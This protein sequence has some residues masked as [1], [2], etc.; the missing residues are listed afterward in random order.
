[1]IIRWLQNIENGA[2]MRNKFEEYLTKFEEVG[3][4]R[5]NYVATVMIEGLPGAVLDEQLEFEGGAIGRVVGMK[6]DRLKVMLLNGKPISPSEKVAR[7]GSKVKIKVSDKLLGKTTDALANPIDGADLAENEFEEREIDSKP[8]GIFGRKRINRRFSTGVMMVD[9]LVPLGKGQRELVIGDRKTGKS[10]LLLQATL[11][12]AREGSVCIYSAVAKK[13]SEIIDIQR[14]M[15]GQG[16]LNQVIIVATS[17][18]DTAGE[19]YIGPY[20]AMTMAEYFRDKGRDVLVVVDDMSVH[21]KYCREIGLVSKKFPGRNSYPGDIFFTHSRLL[22]RAGNFMVNGREVSITCL[23]VAETVQGDLSGYISTNI[24]SMTDGHIFFDGDLYFRGRR[25]AINTFLSV[26]RVG[27]QTQTKLQIDANRL[28]TDLLTNYEKTQ[29]FQKFGAELGENSRQILAVGE[30]IL[31]FFDQPVSTVVPENLQLILL[32][33]LVSGMW[34]GKGIDKLVDRYIKE[35][36]FRE[37]ADTTV[38]TS[39]SMS[40][41]LENVRG[42]SSYFNALL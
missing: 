32:A 20:T 11:A 5:E 29:S 18:M 13:K 36:E 30:K 1:M 31:T 3:F 22:E 41:L 10:L 33:L 42:K 39:E 19:V 21:A 26:T 37:V 9:L 28:L 15:E 25:P 35:N 27:R 40:R 24:M 23:P 4:V 34:S 38:T 2:D 16:I 14:Y 12:Q 6:K 7:T 17:A 8:W